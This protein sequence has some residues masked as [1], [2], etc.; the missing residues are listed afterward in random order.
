MQLYRGRVQHFNNSNSLQNYKKMKVIIL[1]ISYSLLSMAIITEY[2]REIT[3]KT[4]VVSAVPTAVATAVA[5]AVNESKT[6]QFS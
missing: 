1:I 2:E 6:Q 3:T 4:A 5:T